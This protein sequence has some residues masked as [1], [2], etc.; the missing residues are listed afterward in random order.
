MKHLLKIDGKKKHFEG[1]FYV[2]SEQGVISSA[3]LT[4]EDDATILDISFDE[5]DGM[6][7]YHGHY[8][9]PLAAG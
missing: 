1:N 5:V 8:M 7:N 3:Y 9:I 2:D 4:C 6:M